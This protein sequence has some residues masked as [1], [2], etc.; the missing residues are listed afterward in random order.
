[1]MIILSIIVVLIASIII[2]SSAISIQ[3]GMDGSMID[4]T[5]FDLLI[6]DGLFGLLVDLL[7]PDRFFID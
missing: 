7:I 1:M 3:G 4:W 6:D 5:M 2:S